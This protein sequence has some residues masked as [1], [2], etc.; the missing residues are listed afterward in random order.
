[1]LV[2]ATRKQTHDGVQ[3]RCSL[4]TPTW[5]AD[6]SARAHAVAPL[7]TLLS[8][9]TCSLTKRGKTTQEPR[10]TQEEPTWVAVT[11]AS[12]DAAAMEGAVEGAQW[13]QQGH[14]ICLDSE[15]GSLLQV[16]VVV[17]DS[18]VE[19]E[20]QDERFTCLYVCSMSNIWAPNRQAIMAIE[21]HAA[22]P[23]CTHSCTHSSAAG[24]GWDNMQSTHDSQVNEGENLDNDPRLS[25]QKAPSMQ[26]RQRQRLDH[27]WHLRTPRGTCTANSDSSGG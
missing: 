11:I 16:E 4:D 21:M 6:A 25:H 19:P 9:P 24:P 1:M 26:H 18:A 17:E 15:V 13:S 20:A 3:T 23:S 12:A 10:F 22:R 8:A 14:P 2:A 27:A 5:V 7:A